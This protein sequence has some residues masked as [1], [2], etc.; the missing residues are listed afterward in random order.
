M[1]TPGPLR[2][3]L[4]LGTSAGGM[5]RHVR[6]L[7]TEL[8]AGAG[9]DVTVAGPAD[10]VLTA[11]AEGLVSG[12]V[13]GLAGVAYE[14]VGI[15]AGP[16][17]VADLRTVRRL[18]AL[19]GQVQVVHAHGLRAGALGVLAVRALPSARRPRIVVTLHNAL[20]GADRRTAL[21]HRALEH[22]VARGADVVL[23]VSPDLAAS[24]RRA[25]AGDVRPAVV[26]APLLPPARAGREQVRRELG[27]PPGTVLLV[28]VARLAPQKG[29]PDLLD[30]VRRLAAGDSPVRAVVAGHGPLA[31]GLRAD[32]AARGL[33]VTLLGERQD[34]GDLLAAADVVVIPS[35]W[36]GQPLILQ[37]ALR[38]GAA[39]VATDSGGTA[40]LAGDG[41]VL[42]PPGRPALLA[43]AIAGLLG[44][45]DGR[46]RLRRRALSRSRDLPTTADGVQALAA[47]YRD[48]AGTP[49]P[50]P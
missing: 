13:A 16:R 7:G 26:P 30:A 45:P 8:A 6:D 22:L 5:R 31:A 48:L 39:I 40:A 43:G 20:V 18:S 2:V 50:T 27:V 34:V 29:L 1:S 25:G 4:V 36:E 23:A 14:P 44:D 49:A 47:L 12:P 35:L 21:V 32:I 46:A 17:P 15:A 10:E 42:V 41:A 37:E 19:A 9:F 38:A 24:A 3:L 33:P 28:T 11:A